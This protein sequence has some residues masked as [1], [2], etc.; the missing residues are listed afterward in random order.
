MNRFLL[1]VS[2]R[3]DDGYANIVNNWCY[4]NHMWMNKPR[5]SDHGKVKAVDELLVYCA[6]TVSN[7]N[8]R[9][10]L[11]FMVVVIEVSPDKTTF[12]LGK[13]HS[14][15]SPLSRMAI[16]SL[17]EQDKLQDIFRKCGQQG[18]NIAKLDPLAALEVLE[19]VEAKP[20]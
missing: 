20:V 3:T 19:L 15:P 14:F 12:T 13:P 7:S 8:H 17:V 2:T 11:A 1:E 4:A 16:R 10:R 9:G 5:D 18:F 6:Q